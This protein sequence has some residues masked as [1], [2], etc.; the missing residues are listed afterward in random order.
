M[1]TIHYVY[2]VQ[3]ALCSVHFTEKV[4]SKIDLLITSLNNSISYYIVAATSG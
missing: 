4:L 2:T 3:Y 1:Q